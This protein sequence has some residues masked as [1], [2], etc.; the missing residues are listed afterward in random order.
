MT[1][2]AKTKMPKSITI[3]ERVADIEITYRWFSFLTIFLTVFSVAWNGALY[4]FFFELNSGGGNDL[5]WLLTIH[6]LVGAGLS[7]YAFI[8][9]FNRTHIKVGQGIIEVRHRPFPWP[10]QKLLYSD[11]INQLYA[12]EN[13]RRNSD[14]HRSVSYDV[15]AR[16]KSERMVKVLT[17]LES[18]AQARYIERAIESQLSIEDRPV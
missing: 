8:S 1:D 14:G 6:A 7:Y 9:W 12:R 16:L 13:V 15:Y 17:G 2:S 5:S 10:G 4:F 3:E 11:D 18:M